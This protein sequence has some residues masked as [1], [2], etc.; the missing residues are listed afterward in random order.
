MAPKNSLKFFS[1][2][3]DEMSSLRFNN[4]FRLRKT[5]RAAIR[6]KQPPKKPFHHVSRDKILHDSWS[7]SAGL[8]R[9]FSDRHFER[10]EGPGDEVG[11]LKRGRQGSVTFEFSAC[12]TGKVAAAGRGPFLFPTYLGRSKGLCSQ[13]KKE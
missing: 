3:H 2:K 11:Q 10:G 6:R 4:G 12:S 8:A 7:I 1:R 13:G 9:G 5:N